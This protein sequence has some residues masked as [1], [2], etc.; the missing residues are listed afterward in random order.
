MVGPALAA[1]RLP[2]LT[3]SGKRYNSVTLHNYNPGF[4]PSL[5]KA[6]VCVAGIAAAQHAVECGPVSERRVLNALTSA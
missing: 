2:R 4:S 1:L 3:R 5:R 6:H